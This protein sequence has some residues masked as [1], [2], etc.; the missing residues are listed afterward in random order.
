LP[1]KRIALT[2]ELED[3]APQF[4]IR[5]KTAINPFTREPMILK[6]KVAT[7]PVERQEAVRDLLEGRG[8]STDDAGVGLTS[9][10]DGTELRWYFGDD[11]TGGKGSEVGI[12]GDEITFALAS[13]LFEVIQAAD[14]A[15]LPP[16]DEGPIAVVDSPTASK[17]KRGRRRKVVVRTVLELKDW[18]EEAVDRELG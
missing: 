1:E 11:G 4:Q 10:Y 15:I 14:M 13:I 9:L 5:E 3:C 2:F 18:L 8:S 17:F 7:W 6:S 16:S 12:V